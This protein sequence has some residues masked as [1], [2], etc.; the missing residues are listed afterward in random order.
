M[1]HI[2]KG[3]R[4][5]GWLSQPDIIPD[6][7]SSR[8]NSLMHQDSDASSKHEDSTSMAYQQTHHP[9]GIHGDQKDLSVPTGKFHEN[10]TRSFSLDRS[11]TEKLDV[12][13]ALTTAHSGLST[14]SLWSLSNPFESSRGTSSK[15]TSTDTEKIPPETPIPQNYYTSD[16]FR[17]RPRRGTVGAVIDTIIPNAIQR[18]FTESSFL[19][20]TSIWQTYEKAKERSAQLQRKIWAQVL[21]EYAI[22]ALILIFIYFVL[23][24]MP[25]WNGAV[26]W[27]WWVIAH[28]FV[29]PGGFGITLGIALL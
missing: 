24:G 29:L 12:S 5:K 3:H 26:Y 20:R 8:C 4:Q 21:F 10:H 18:R 16:N 9:Q 2:L 23:V 11:M 15:R 17:S 14:S 6:L 7:G 13:R 1:V 27:L 28:K 25:F 19:R 22:Y